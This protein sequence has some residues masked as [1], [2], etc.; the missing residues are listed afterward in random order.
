MG[1]IMKRSKSIED[2]VQSF[3][4][5]TQILLNTLRELVFSEV[6]ECEELLSY[7]IPSYKY[8]SKY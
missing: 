1:V 7:G 2:Y 8:Q 4:K 5:E 3:P 6:P